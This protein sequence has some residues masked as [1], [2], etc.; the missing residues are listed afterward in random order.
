MSS[1][2]S[3]VILMHVSWT[4]DVNKSIGDLYQVA[5]DITG[6]N[7]YFRIAKNYWLFSSFWVYFMNVLIYWEYDSFRKHWI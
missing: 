1:D 5:S 6:V 7:V 3:N 4:Q 2:K